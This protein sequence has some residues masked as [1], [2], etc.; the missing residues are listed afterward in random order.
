M[1]MNWNVPG[2][3]APREAVTHRLDIED[4]LSRLSVQVDSFFVG[5]F[6]PVTAPCRPAIDRVTVLYVITGAG[7]LQW[8]G[9][10]L[11]LRKGMI[12]LIPSR[13]PTVLCGLGLASDNLRP[14]QAGNSSDGE[15]AADSI[16]VAI[17]TVT[18]SAGHG[19]G[20]FDSIEEPVAEDSQDGLLQY[21]FNGILAEVEKPG[22]GSKCI[23][24]ALIKQV[25]IVLLRRRLMHE[26]VA[27]AAPLYL[28][29]ANPNLAI[30]INKIQNSHAE[31]LP[32]SGLAKLVGMTSLGLT[33]EFERIFGET[34]LDYIQGVRLGQA[35]KLLTHTD[36]PIKSIAASVGFASRSHFSRAFSKHRGQDPTAFRKSATDLRSERTIKIDSSWGAKS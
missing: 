3:P 19:L 21:I 30:V 36:L 27:V 2:I 9:G 15:S 23:V 10:E 11:A 28:T 14:A 24:E 20:Y 7:S 32:I 1:R 34:L 22:I 6:C 18:A 33:S 5:G 12:A 25:L 26:D 8:S 29:I 16:V 17:S 13:L 4:L 35:T 31:R